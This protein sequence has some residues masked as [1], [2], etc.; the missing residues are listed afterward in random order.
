MDFGAA[1]RVRGPA[2]AAPIRLHPVQAQRR[3]LRLL[4]A[5]VLHDAE[6]LAAR[7]VSKHMGRQRQVGAGAGEPLHTLYVPTIALQPSTK[8]RRAKPSFSYCTCRAR[9]FLQSCASSLFCRVAFFF[10]FFWKIH[11]DTKKLFGSF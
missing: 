11:T 9:S 4:L 3:W 6:Q 5:E 1:R 7:Q 10:E 8:E 2:A